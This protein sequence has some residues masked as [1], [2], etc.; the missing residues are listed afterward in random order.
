MKYNERHRRIHAWNDNVSCRVVSQVVL[1]LIV[2]CETLLFQET[3]CFYGFP[4]TTSNLAFLF[5]FLLCVFII[6][7]SSN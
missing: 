5:S 3:I 6:S 2:V 4:A 1:S 7:R